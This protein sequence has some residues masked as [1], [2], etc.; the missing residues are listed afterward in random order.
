MAYQ[1]L[2]TVHIKCFNSENPQ[3]SEV[4]CFFPHTSQQYKGDK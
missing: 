4:Y 1:I 3:N 2:S